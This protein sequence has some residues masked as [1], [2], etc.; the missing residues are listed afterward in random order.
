MPEVKQ[1]K[2]HFYDIMQDIET[3]SE[4]DYPKMLSLKVLLLSLMC[5][6]VKELWM[7]RQQA[8]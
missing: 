6:N 2:R 3:L 5:L 8:S 4:I 7:Q 1:I